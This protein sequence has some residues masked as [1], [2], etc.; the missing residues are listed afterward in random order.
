MTINERRWD[1]GP[2]IGDYDRPGSFIAASALQEIASGKIFDLVIVGA[3]GAGAAAAIEATSRGASVLVLEKM[4]YAGGSTQV[5]G[6]TIRVIVDR[7]RALDHYRALAQGSTPDDVFETYIDGLMAVPE[8][9][10][11]HGGE[12]VQDN[13][14]GK[15]IKRR[16]C[17][18]PRIGSAFPNFPFPDAMGPR[19]HVRPQRADRPYGAAL[20]DFLRATLARLEVP[21]VTDVRVTELIQEYPERRIAG[22]VAEAGGKTVRIAARAVILSCG[23]FAWDPEMMRQYYGVPLPAASPPGRNTGDGIRMAQDAGADLWHMTATSSTLAYKVPELDA[24]L[25]CE[26][27][28][29][30]FIMVD[31]RGRRYA[32][33][34][35]LETHSFTHPMLVQDS[36]EGHFLRIPSYIVVDETTRLAGRLATTGLGANRH[37]PWSEDN[38][39]EIERGWVLKAD[40]LEE[41]AQKLGIPEAQL[42]S[43][44]AE[45]NAACDGEKAD[46]F[47]RSRSLMRPIRQGPFYGAAVYPAL[48][49]TQGGPRR[50]AECQ[51]LRP[52]GSPIRG[53]YSA[54][55]LG[56]IWTRLYP[57]GGNVSEAIV[58]G[59]VAA[60]KALEFA[61]Q[62]ELAANA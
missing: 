49:N 8:W 10:S 42:L 45:Y 16:V 21:V 27:P 14:S 12:L 59:R 11:S 4:A 41:L 61:R 53:L 46:S 2:D 60:E 6:G 30:G 26:I 20:W 3:G 50:D 18:V 9:I 44:V 25:P 29:P 5:S 34:T 54:G 48:L 15:V 32:S 22:V 47:G 31:Q 28:D 43:T 1:A 23:G 33:E 7:D 55:E 56:S 36:V 38:S 57:G 58:S 40:T 17:P 19:S 51:V 39:V 52:D 13:F 24:A 35:D 37:Y 62:G